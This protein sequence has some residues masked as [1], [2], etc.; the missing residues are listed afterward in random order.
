[1]YPDRD[2]WR[3]EK[4]EMRQRKITPIVL[5]YVLLSIG[6]GAMLLTLVV[7]KGAFL[8]RIVYDFSYFADFFDHVRRFYLGL[9]NVYLEGMHAC[10]PPLAYML[11]G[12]T[13]SVI[14]RQNINN[15][16]AVSTNG[17]GMLVLCMFTA[18]LAAGFVFASFRLYQEQNMAAKK[19]LIGL[20]LISYPFWLAIER[21]NMSMVVLIV[22]LYAMAL[23]DSEKGWE[24]ELALIL[25]AIAAGLKLYPAVFGVL[26]LAEKRYREAVRLV[27][28]G[29]FFF[30]APFLFFQG[31][32]GL[33]LFLHN[34]SAV[35][36]GVTGV[37]IAGITGRI[38]VVLGLDLSLAHSI[39]K[40]ISGM[41]FAVVLIL[42]FIR[43]KSWKT[44]TFLSSL[45]IVFV[46]ASGTYC[47]IY[48]V[49]PFF[50]YL[51]E[52]GKKERY[53]KIDYVYAVLFALVFTAYPLKAFGSS[54][55]LYISLYFLL[56]VLII[57]ESWQAV[58][59][60][61]DRRKQAGSE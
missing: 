24:R 13:A 26:Y 36:S 38:G 17:A 29:L 14:Y 43:G 5:V 25:I 18:M 32:I 31:T 53:E 52:M 16:D 23:M 19:C 4:S 20:L 58:S 45:M 15:P 44:I 22:L 47:L 37:S 33:K 1:M 11:Y 51:N 55:M 10:F 40:V 30:F 6:T 3:K 60:W 27:L 41:Y 21:G 46:A 35:N 59:N 42:C 54:G 2:W 9:D 39:G 61:R 7:S 48:C 57:D 8:E 50:I 56:V 12:L 34:I 28:Y 49:I